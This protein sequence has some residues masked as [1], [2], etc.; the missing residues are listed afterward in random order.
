MGSDDLK[1]FAVKYI[2]WL[3]PDV[4]VERPDHVLAQVMNLG[5]FEDTMRL[6]KIAGRDRLRRVLECAEAGWFSPAAWHYWHY[7][8]DVSQLEQVPPLPVRI[9]P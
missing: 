7:K 4:A 5:T 8:L 9:I 6:I 3:S 2:W 1:F